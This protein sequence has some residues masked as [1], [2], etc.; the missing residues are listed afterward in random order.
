MSRRYG[1]ISHRSAAT[2]FPG[3]PLVGYELGDELKAAQKAGFEIGDPLR[4]WVI[5][6][7]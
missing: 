7:D 2:T 3:L 5:A 1:A 6:R 4:V